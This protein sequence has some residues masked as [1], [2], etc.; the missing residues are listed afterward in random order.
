MLAASNNTALMARMG[1]EQTMVLPAL[2][3]MAIAGRI[4]G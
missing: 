3:G 1:P 4:I 2:A